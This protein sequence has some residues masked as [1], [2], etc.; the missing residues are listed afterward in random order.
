MRVLLIGSGGREHALAWGLARSP[1]LGELHAAPGNPGIAQLATCHDVGA[2]DLAGLT[3]LAVSLGADLV[4]VGPEA[5]LVAGIGDRMAA[6]GIVCFGPDAE[7]ARL[8]GS[9]AFA[10]QVMAAA[11]VPTAA[12]S[13]CDT[14]AAAQLA[15]AEADGNVVI[16]ADGLAAGKGVFVC[17]SVEE[18]E[19]AIQACLVERRFG[20][21]GT[22]LLVEQRLEGPEVS[23][24]ALSDGE[25]VVPLAPARDYKRAL[26]GD[27]G[28]NTGGMGCI[29]PVPELDRGLVDEVVATVHRPV[30]AE[31]RRR[32]TPFR[33]CLYAGLMLTPDGPRVL[34]FNARW[35]DPETQVLVPRLAGDL[36]DA[37]HRVATGR[38][39]GAELEV[40][41][42]ACVSV[43]LAAKGY[44]DA[45]EAGAEIEGVE[46]ASELEGVSVFHAGTRREGDSLVV[47]GGR[48]LNVSATAH[49]LA[50]ARERAYEAAGLIRFDGMQ[51]RS[52]IGEVA[53]HV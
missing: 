15:V 49:D 8:E 39:A 9:K 28:P 5:P 16:K 48:V 51:R 6:A 7:A 24:L 12:F 30:I 21:S 34:E 4:V 13:V 31:M 37:L 43:V 36:L 20:G 41:P 11:G 44:P 35:G 45:P 53:A 1:G 25:H 22:R 38:L 29:S 42:D 3:E 40:R 32:G 52:D 33:G 46:A 19:A 26:D 17:G 10:K 50:A 23:M 27:R 2:G 14:V 47:S 18:A